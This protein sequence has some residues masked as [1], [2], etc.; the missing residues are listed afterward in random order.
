MVNLW[1]CLCKYGT[2]NATVMYLLSEP[3]AG[4]NVK[5]IKWEPNTPLYNLK[6]NGYYIHEVRASDNFIFLELM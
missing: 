6:V 4:E 3:K 1:E 2:Q 5:G